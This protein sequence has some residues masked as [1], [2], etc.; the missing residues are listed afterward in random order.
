MPISYDISGLVVKFMVENWGLD[1]FK[2]FFAN[3]DKTE[4]IRTMCGVS[5]EQLVVNY[6]EWLQQFPDID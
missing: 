3:P 4:A 1:N 5:P 6:K 2:R